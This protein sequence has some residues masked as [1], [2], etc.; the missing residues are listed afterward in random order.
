LLR[1]EIQEQLAPKRPRRIDIRPLRLPAG[2]A[3]IMERPKIA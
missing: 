1:I 2:S 3:K